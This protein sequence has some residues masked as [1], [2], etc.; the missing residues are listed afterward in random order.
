[1]ESG[2]GSLVNSLDGNVSSSLNAHIL[3]IIKRHVKINEGIYLSINMLFDAFVQCIRQYSNV[4]WIF[5][6]VNKI[7]LNIHSSF[8]YIQYMLPLVS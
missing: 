8:S 3:F 2:S 6:V 5:H 4:K 1:M 7:I